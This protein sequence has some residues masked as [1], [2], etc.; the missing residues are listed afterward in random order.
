MSSLSRVSIPNSIRKTIQNIK[1]ITGNHSDDE[2]YAMLRECSMDPNDTA[3]N[4]LSQDT[5][6]E[7]KR[8]RDKR[9]ENISNG[10]TAD[11]RQ[12]SGMQG[13]KTRVGQRN[14]SSRYIANEAGDGG[15]SIVGKPNGVHPIKEKNS[16]LSSLSAYEETKGKE[17]A[18]TPS[19]LSVNGP[20]NVACE[21]SGHRLV[22][23]LPAERGSSIS[24]GIL[25]AGINK[26]GIYSSSSDSKLVP[27]LDS[28]GPSAANINKG[29]VGTQSIVDS[30]APEVHESGSLAPRELSNL[31]QKKKIASCNLTNTELPLATNGKAAAGTDCRFMK[32]KMPSE[33]KVVEKDTLSEPLQTLLSSAHRNSSSR[34]SSNYGSQTQQLIGSQKA[35]G[36][37]K[38]RE[39]KPT[40]SNHILPYGTV[41]TS[42]TVAPVA[43]ESIDW[44][45][46]T[47]NASTSAE[48][49]VK[50]KKVE[51]LHFSK[52]QH[53]I[54][55]SHI[56]V[57]AAERSGLSFGSFGAYFELCTNYTGGSDGDRNSTGL[58]EGL[59]EKENAV[60][61]TSSS[62]QTASPTVQEGDYSDHHD[63][64]K[65]GSDR[66]SPEEAENDESLNTVPE[67]DHDKLN[68]VLPPDGPQYSVV[69]T[70]PSHANFGSMPPVLGNQHAPI[71]IS[72]TLARDDSHPPNFA[73]QQSFD[74][75]ANY[76]TQLYR[77][78]A[79]IDGRFSPLHVP[80]A[81]NKYNGN[82][83]V[84]STQSSL[85]SHENGNSM[86]LSNASPTSHVPQTVGIMQSPVSMS[87]QSGPIFRQPAGFISHYPP[88][89]IPYNQFYSPLF[90]PSPII[91][92]FLSNTS[93]PQQLQAA[94]VYP[95]PL[96]TTTTGVEFPAPQCK[97]GTNLG[98]S[99]PANFGHYNALSSGYSTINTAIT[100][101]NGDE[102]LTTSQFKENNVYAN[103]HQTEGSTMWIPTPG[104]EIP[105][106]P[107]GSFY[108]LPPQGQHVA[109]A[110]TQPGHGV[111]AGLYP[112][113]SVAAASIHPFPQPS[114]T[115]AS[116]L[117][118]W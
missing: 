25:A 46:Y 72:E 74:P 96:G 115:M 42:E 116:P 67:H 88:N 38:E 109:F 78:G 1:E 53:V 100:N 84:L 83:T 58:S 28:L 36:S 21:D 57:P 95:A 29:E 32:G 64:P 14:Y 41:G 49:P 79:G 80:G 90:L 112:A 94:N 39:P 73:V 76:Y 70:A 111:F 68:T 62:N 102:E 9:K 77:P 54:V 59:Q 89:Y 110:P 22:S 19:S 27:S 69:Q 113:Q 2:I 23:T 86:V 6:H 13:R 106:L 85:S 81:A 43:V 55:P 92:H 99:M 105:G 33:C 65:S 60:E 8:K 66:F 12:R 98:N 63:S 93:F 17:E 75:S 52:G 31:N 107:A 40:A 10:E 104:R 35:G 16:M 45:E 7:V 44:L 11:S 4:L 18:L 30:N 15:T 108:N 34:P 56:H 97:P 61:E 87:Q 103:G 5:F 50:L 82:V 47:K 118:K 3:H 37:S 117:L 20:T 24:E 114:Q 51:E 48:A 26:L 71:D 101:L 91:H